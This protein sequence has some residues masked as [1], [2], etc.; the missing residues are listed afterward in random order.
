MDRGGRPANWLRGPTQ[1]PG[2]TG[3]RSQAKSLSHTCLHQAFPL[4]GLQPKGETDPTGISP[5]LAARAP[6]R[7]AIQSGCRTLSMPASASGVT[8]PESPP[9]KKREM[10]PILT[11]SG[12]LPAGLEK[13][14]A[15]FCQDL[16]S[17]RLPGSSSR[18]NGF[19]WQGPWGMSEAAVG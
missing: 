14:T 8:W 16:A 10:A 5:V 19:L 3:S 6:G 9:V 4:R 11:Y 18:V 12:C 13:E 1:S 2:S 15:M 7:K 17:R